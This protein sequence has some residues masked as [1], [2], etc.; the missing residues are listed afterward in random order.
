VI[1]LDSEVWALTEPQK[2]VAN[3]LLRLIKTLSPFLN[4][5]LILLDTS[6]VDHKLSAVRTVLSIRTLSCNCV[7]CGVAA[8]GTDVHGILSI[9]FSTLKKIPGGLSFL[10]PRKVLSFTCEARLSK[11]TFLTFESIASSTVILDSDYLMTC[12]LE[13]YETTG[14]ATEFHFK[15][16]DIPY[17][18]F[19]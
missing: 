5:M 15:C 13:S 12:T 10:I 6:R 3:M 17:L 19:E 7:T 11:Q 9:K 4:F 14:R 8:A 16:N 18:I 1:L 2:V